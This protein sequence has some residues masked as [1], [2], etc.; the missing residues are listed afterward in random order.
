MDTGNPNPPKPIAGNPA[1]PFCRSGRSASPTKSVRHGDR[2]PRFNPNAEK[3][4][5]LSVIELGSIRLGWWSVMVGFFF[6]VAWEIWDILEGFCGSGNNFLGIFFVF[7]FGDAGFR[8]HEI[9][10]MLIGRSNLSDFLEKYVHWLRKDLGCWGCRVS[11]CH[12]G[13]RIRGV[14]WRVWCFYRRGQDSWDSV[15]HLEDHIR[16]Q[17]LQWNGFMGYNEMRTPYNMIW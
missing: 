15:K 14:I 8:E 5:P 10:E 11:S 4:S 3:V 2:T 12:L 1:S 9:S 17:R 6:S 7:F 13:S 16:S